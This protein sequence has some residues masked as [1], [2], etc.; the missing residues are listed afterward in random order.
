VWKLLF[1]V[2]VSFL[3]QA[4]YRNVRS[5]G[6]R[7]KKDPNGIQQFPP[8]T[9]STLDDGQAEHVARQNSKKK[10]SQHL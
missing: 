1:S 9:N 7:E 5:T 4:N 3:E 6:L 10:M 2:W 8:A